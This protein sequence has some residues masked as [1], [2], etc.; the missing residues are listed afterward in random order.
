MVY[1]LGER[2]TIIQSNQYKLYVCTEI[3]HYTPSICTITVWAPV[4][5]A[6]SPNYLGGRD[7]EDQGSKPTWANS[8]QDPQK[9]PT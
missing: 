1:V 9:Y 5:H 2:Y 3:P 8:S 7:L 6:C 4:A